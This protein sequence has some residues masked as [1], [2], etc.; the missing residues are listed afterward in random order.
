MIK[1]KLKRR[2]RKKFHLGE[3]HAFGFEISVYFKNGTDEIQFDKFWYEF[4]QEIEKNGLICGGGGDFKVWKVFVTS[5]KKFASPTN[6]EKESIRIW[7]ENCFEVES[8][9]FGELKDA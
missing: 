8:F 3:F 6:I 4:I 5:E 7:L 9:K 2:L 1:S